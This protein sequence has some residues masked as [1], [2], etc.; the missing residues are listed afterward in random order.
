MVVTSTLFFECSFGFQGNSFD[1]VLCPDRGGDSNQTS[2]S[3]NNWGFAMPCIIRDGDSHGES[4]YIGFLEVGKTALE[5]IDN[6]L[7][8]FFLQAE[9][10]HHTQA[11]LEC[12]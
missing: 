7:N 12:A 6:R 4:G 1:N 3:Y 2:S 5:R 11:I 8:V 9:W 10:R